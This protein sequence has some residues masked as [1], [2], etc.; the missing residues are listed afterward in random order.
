MEVSRA[1]VLFPELIADG[2]QYFVGLAGD[3][4]TFIIDRNFLYNVV[5]DN[6]WIGLN[7]TKQPIK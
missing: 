5:Q 6:K 7:C 3:I 4:V 1:L 2:T